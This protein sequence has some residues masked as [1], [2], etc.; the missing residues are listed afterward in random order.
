MTTLFE[1]LGGKES[2]NVAVDKFYKKVLGDDR[3][4]YF[5]AQTDMKKQAQH[6]KLFLTYAFGGAPNY[7]GK[8]MGAAHKHLV[9]EMGLNDRHFD[10]IAENLNA[11]LKEMNVP[12]SLIAEVASIVESTRDS[13]LNRDPVSHQR[14]QKESLLIQ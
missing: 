11:T 14:E 8:S 3:V 4:N 1:K 10:A 5:F 2:V 9:K 12:E 6:Q 7:S 13:V